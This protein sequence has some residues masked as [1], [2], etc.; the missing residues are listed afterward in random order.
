MPHLYISPA[1]LALAV[2]L[3][4]IFGGTF[5]LI[6][7]GESRWSVAKRMTV[8]LTGLA[9]LAVVPFWDVLITAY[10][11]AQLCSRAGAQIPAPVRA[12]GFLSNFA[13]GA[14]AIGRGFSYLEQIQPTGIWLY[15]RTDEGFSVE[16]FGKNYQ[17]KSRYEH[18]Y[19]P[20]I[21]LPDYLN[22]SEVRSLVR[23]RSKGTVLANGVSYRI[24]PG[25]LD[26]HTVGRISSFTW[27]C[28]ERAADVHL[29]LLREG[30]LPEAAQR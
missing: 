18:E 8:A 21:V 26:R 12:S 29:Q 7:I 20:E 14:A 1:G 30:I 24:Y 15:K 19:D 25:W 11:A 23:D 6:V 28:P 5:V 3:L 17:P 13:D 22:L 9:M 10:Q 2:G 4:L 16:K 27:S